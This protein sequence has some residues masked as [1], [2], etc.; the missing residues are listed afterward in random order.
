MI[1]ESQ[2]RL[3]PIAIDESPDLAETI[4][5]TLPDIKAQIVYAVR[6]EAAHSLVDILRRRTTIAMQAN[7]GLDVLPI[8]S[9]VLGK[10]CGW[11]EEKLDRALKDY[12]NYMENN[13]IP[14]YQ[15]AKSYVTSS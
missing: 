7:Y 15:T 5:P 2:K 9:E 8:V 14:D 3:K 13:C 11:E 4:T 12:H 6:K 1:H 10:H